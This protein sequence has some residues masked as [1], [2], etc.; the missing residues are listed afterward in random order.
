MNGPNDSEKDEMVGYGRPPIATRFQKGQSGNPTGRPKNRKSIGT[1]IRDASLRK[2]KVHEGNRVRSIPKIQAAY[3]VALNKAC[4]GDLRAFT[5]VIDVATKFGILELPPNEQNISYNHSAAAA[6]AIKTIEQSIE[7]I[8]QAN[9]E[10]VNENGAA[11][12][13]KPEPEKS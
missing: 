8:R 4:K 11:P 1:I 7:R 6:S 13:N 10:C 5:K 9:I 3:E 2:I 12:G